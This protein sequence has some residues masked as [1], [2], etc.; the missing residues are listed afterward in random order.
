MRLYCPDVAGSGT[1]LVRDLVKREAPQLNLIRQAVDTLVSRISTQR[2]KPQYIV[3]DGSFDL[4]R[5]ARLRTRVLEGQLF[6]GRG[7]EIM[8]LVLVDALALGTGHVVAYVD[9]DTNKIECERAA[10]GEIVIDP[11][12]GIYGNPCRVQRKR[13]MSRDVIRELYDVSDALLEQ[14]K[15]P[16]DTD[17][18]LMFLPRDKA[19]DEVMVYEAW[20]SPPGESTEGGRHVIALSSATLVDEDWDYMIP[21]VRLCGWTRQLGYWGV[22]IA[23]LGAECQDRYNTNEAKIEYMQRLGSTAWVLADRNAEVRIE[24]L[25]NE[26]LS[27]VRFTSRGI[28]PKI[29]VFSATPIDLVQENERI[30]ERFLSMLGISQMAAEAKRPAGLDSGAAQRTYE[31]I[32]SLRHSPQS[33]QYED[34]FMQLVRVFEDLNDYVQAT[35]AG[36]YSV[37]ARTQRGLVPLV[38]QVKWSDANMPRE[39]Y[40][41]TCFPT[42]Q[43]PSTV[44]GRL[45]AL[46]E[47]VASGFVS[48]PYAQKQM[49]DMPD[50]DMQRLELADLDFVMWQIEEILDGKVVSPESYQDMTL[51]A[52]TARRAYLQVKSRGAPEELLEVLRNFIDDCMDELKK[53]QA[54]APAP[55]QGAQPMPP[56]L[57]P[58]GPAPAEVAA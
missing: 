1:T 22:G 41:I 53:Q 25:T 34:V 11:R 20:Y 14:A 35:R 42:S 29:Q 2:P 24:R 19:L 9:P 6:D 58:G 48:R 52:D 38:K 27:I 50:D 12:E 4:E 57:G 3:T 5:V 44:P 37:M 13:S 16:T 43:L 31:D 47:W 8:P 56:A 33:K 17:R 18:D 15:G 7:Y 49:I 39:Q 51:A 45:A 10:P 46:S 40:R 55:D 36:A 21:V 30:R 26:P 32:T 28:E 54:P 23:E